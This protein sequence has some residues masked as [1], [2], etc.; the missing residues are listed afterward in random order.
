[1]KFEIRIFKHQENAIKLL[2]KDPSN[3]RFKSFKSFNEAYAFSYEYDLH[4]DEAPSLSQ[5][6]AN[7]KSNKMKY[8]SN[9]YQPRSLPVEVEKLPFSAPK[10]PEVNQL[11]QFIEKND[12]ESFQKKI[13]SNPRFLISA[14]D[15]ANLC[16]VK[17]T[18]YSSFFFLWQIIQ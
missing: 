2:K 10:K 5:V 17:T 3:R 13:I 12:L 4:E 15:T 8:T 16:Q 18:S 9:E 7:F 1:M 14:G 6:K 11:R